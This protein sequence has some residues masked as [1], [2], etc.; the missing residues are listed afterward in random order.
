M[1]WNFSKMH[2]IGNDYIYFNCLDRDFPNPSKNAVRLSNRNF[3]IGADGIV[4]I[5]S[6]DSADFRMQMFNAD[7]SEAEMCGNAIRCVGKFLF[8]KGISDSKKISVDTLAGVMLLE[9]N[10]EDRKVRSVRVNMGKPELSSDKI[11]VIVDSNQCVAQ[12]FEMEGFLANMT[13]VS[14]GNPH[15]VFFVDEV[16]DDQILEIGPK[17]EMHSIFPKKVNV[18]FVKVISQSEL[19]M[20]VWERGSGETLACGTGAAAVCVAASL[21][22]LASKKVKINLLGGQLELEWADDG[23]VYKTGPAELSYTGVVEL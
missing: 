21:N 1:E 10:V 12:S 5:K 22:N 7:G 15:V 19:E 6:S 2:G 14:M 20:R 23:C 9:L 16:T 3:G 18:E 13:C 11:P 17:I 4:L 8:D